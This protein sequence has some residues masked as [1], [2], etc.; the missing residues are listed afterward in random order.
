[1]ENLIKICLHFTLPHFYIYF[2]LKELPLSLSLYIYIYITYCCL[3]IFIYVVV[4]TDQI[5]KVITYNK[6][7]HR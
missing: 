7:L 6:L 5:T 4:I 3:Y 2:S 1:M